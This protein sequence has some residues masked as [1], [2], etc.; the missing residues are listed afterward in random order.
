MAIGTLEDDLLGE[1]PLERGAEIAALADAAARAAA[2]SGS[3]VV[4]EGPGGIGKSVLLDE[5]A[6]LAEAEGLWVCVPGPPSSSAASRS[7]WRCS[8]SSPR[9]PSSMPMSAEGALRGAAGLAVPL[10]SPA[11]QLLPAGGSEFSVVHGL[12]WLTANLADGRPLALVVDNLDWADEPSLRLCAYLAERIQELPV[13]LVVAHRPGCPDEEAELLRGVTGHRV[14]TRLQPA[15]LSDEGVATLAAATLTAQPTAPFVAACARLTGGNPFLLDQLLSTAVAEGVTPAEPSRLDALA[16]EGVLRTV[17]ARLA[18]LSP[19]AVAIARAVAVLADDAHLRH[20][21]VLADLPLE[22]AV[23]AADTLTG[24]D[25]LRPGEPLAFRHA[26]TA[27]AVLA[28]VP[29]TARAAGHLRAAELLHAEGATPERLAAHLLQAPATGR[30]WVVEAL[31]TAAARARSLGAPQTAV[32]LLRRALDEPPP[33]GARCELLLELGRAE[34][35]AGVPT[36]SDA[37]ARRRSSRRP[38]SSAHE[39]SARSL[40]RRS[41][42]ATTPPRRARTPTRWRPSTAPIPSWPRTC[43]PRSSSSR[44]STATARPTRRRSRRSSTTS[45]SAARRPAGPCWPRWR[46][47]S[48]TRARRATACS[49][50]PTGPWAA[51]RCSTTTA[52]TRRAPTGSSSC[53]SSA[54]SSSASTS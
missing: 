15:P 53:S 30:T 3:L 38:A 40:A 47:T 17:N 51:A 28:D 46:S 37:S 22:A 39:S 11:G 18:R 45:R 43:A 41:R 21:A 4:V 29:P 9:S 19:A 5:A 54:R 20:A 44:P 24:A 49:P 10:L 12:Y 33:T 6:R 50:S 16:P 25:V 23:H 27:A 34:A 35:T 14:A 7:A 52:R 32:G 36:A 2:G 31:R 48:S 13:L 1:A 42:S 8:S 26:L